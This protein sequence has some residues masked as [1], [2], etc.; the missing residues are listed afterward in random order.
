MSLVE[1]TPELKSF[2]ESAGILGLTPPSIENLKNNHPGYTAE[3]AKKCLAFQ[4]RIKNE[5][6]T[7]PVITNNDY[8]A[9]F[10]KGEMTEAQLKAFVVQFSV[11][12]NLFLI[13]QLKKMLNADSLEA[14]RASKEILANEIGVIF[15]DGKQVAGTAPD[16]VSETGSVDGGTFRFK[17]GHF[18]WLLR[19][20]D[21]L[22][23]KFSE[24]GKREHG[25][26]ST[27]FYC[28]EL[29]RL[30]GNENY[31]ISQA[32]SFAVENWAAAG[33]WEELVAGFEAY[34]AKHQ[35]SVPI[36]FFTFH[37]R[38]EGQ[39]A[40]HTQEELEEY[41]FEHSVNENDF[42]RYGLE[43]LDGVQA[44]WDG[45]NKQRLELS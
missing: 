17:A 13:A 45:L 41:Y 9:W 40:E 11:F 18:E 31:A 25:I 28:D 16:L 6:L 19:V 12:S 7:H 43:M 8:S 20:G 21:A 5:L 29:E 33:F 36:G 23:L 2:A 14:M 15:N 27:L 22:G 10:A 42:I 26:P 3:K 1:M 32:A 4:D 39:H 37:S 38:I 44:F 24:M 30:Y 35:C 34:N